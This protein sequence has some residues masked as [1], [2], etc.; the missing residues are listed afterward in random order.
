MVGAGGSSKGREEEVCAVCREARPLGKLDSRLGYCCLVGSR[1][2]RLE[3]WRECKLGP[4]LVERAATRCLVGPL[5]KGR[6]RQAG[7]YF[8][9]QHL[10]PVEQ[11]GLG[12]D[13]SREQGRIGQL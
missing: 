7:N 10:G 13:A 2:D 1:R 3:E 12:D 6:D 8:Q 9:A 4:L 5:E 11:G